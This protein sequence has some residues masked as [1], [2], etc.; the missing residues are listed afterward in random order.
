MNIED[1]LTYSMFF[2]LGF[3]Y[4]LVFIIQFIKKYKELKWDKKYILIFKDIKN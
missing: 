4:G 3:C 2:L 1:I